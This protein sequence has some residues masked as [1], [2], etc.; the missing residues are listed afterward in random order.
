[1]GD[2]REGIGTTMSSK[3]TSPGVSGHRSAVRSHLHW[4][5][6]DRL[7]LLL[8]LVIVIIIASLVGLSLGAL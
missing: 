3:V 1:M 7:A 8:L 6:P 5:S 4:P 2:V